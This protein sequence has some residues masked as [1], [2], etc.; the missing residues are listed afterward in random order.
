ML[1]QPTEVDADRPTFAVFPRPPAAAAVAADD[2]VTA[3]SNRT[4][5]KL[6][7]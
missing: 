6:S 3:V 4:V 7:L 5:V 1:Y 2:A